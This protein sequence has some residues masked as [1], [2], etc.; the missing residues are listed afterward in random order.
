MNSRRS[1]RRLAALL[2][3]LCAAGPAVVL[4]APAFAADVPAARKAAG[5]LAGQLSEDGTLQNPLGGALPDHGLM[6][7]ALYAMYAAGEGDLARP[8]V[9][10]LDEGKHA[11]D[12]FTWDGLVPGQGYDQVIVGGAAA[13][14]LVAA[15]VARRDP[16][17]FGGYDL[18]TETEGAIMRSGPDKGR[19][20][21]YSKD[22]DLASSVS[23]NANVFGQALG[24]I[25]L[26]GVGRN[27]R[28]AIDKLVTQQCSE[29]YFRIYFGY[30]PT[31]ETGDHVTP[32]GRKVST[33]DEG[34]AHDQSAPDGDAT[35]LALSALVAARRAGAR[36]LDAPIARTVAWLRKRQDAGGGWGGGVS[37]EA[38]NTNS[39]GLIVQA[40]ADAGGAKA[41]VARGQAYL[42]SA[43]ATA[44]DAGNRLAEHVGA[45]AYTP[46][47]YRTARSEGIAGIDTWIRASA[48][49]SL[50]LSQVGFHGLTR[51]EKPGGGTP[52]PGTRPPGGKDPAGPPAKEKPLSPRAGAP[53]P[54]PGSSGGTVVTPPR[55][56]TEPGSPTPAG[57]LGR[58]LA[59]RLVDGDHIEVADG[60]TK[61]VDYDL[62]ADLVL[63][64]RALDEQPR[65]A[66]NASRFLLHP[67]SIKAYA[68]GAPYEKGQA[69]YTEPLAKLRIVGG[70]LQSERRPPKG[71]A[72]TVS[73]LDEDLR[74]LR[75]RD[76]RFGDTGRY[77]DPG[78][79]TRRQAWAALAT[80]A[81]RGDAPLEPLTRARCAD[82]GMP[83]EVDAKGCRT[84]DAAATAT[85]ILALN[86]RPG[87]PPGPALP[88]TVP[89]A[90]T[91]DGWPAGRAAALTRA[92]SA[93]SARSALDGAVR[94]TG[95]RLDVAASAHVAAGRQGA[96]LDATATARTLGGL[97]LRDG[98][99]PGAQTK[100]SDVP[101]SI[102]AA[103]GIAGRAWTSAPGSPVAAAVRLPLSGEAAS[104]VERRAAPASAR[105]S[106]T[107]TVL[108]GLLAACAGFLLRP[109]LARRRAPAPVARQ[110][111]P[112]GPEPP[113]GFGTPSPKD[114]P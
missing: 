21:D 23:N 47:E 24:V 25:G 90:S 107:I 60:R 98:G 43:Q 40:L 95:G 48:Q 94:G 76:G 8:I 55:A 9:R 100:R 4:P 45:I 87:D 81:A 37:T 58:Y 51:G 53:A 78:A 35:G 3:A 68:N 10:Y 88:Q 86:G 7:D 22:P 54:V 49:A 13:K 106:W 65:A 84:G 70:F 56:F 111:V 64:L 101:A 80:V 39:T 12:Y 89:A 82:G 63:A 42:T 26:A 5:W 44:A 52:P 113:P 59:G 105:E 108:V 91:G 61:Y 33:C 72:P 74:G 11:S 114:T 99:L 2:A 71:V 85:A 1:P 77:A 97:L 31:D 29:G 17:S 93:L 103:P 38:P 46:A 62:T 34:K 79:S 36:G 75:G 28:L 41:A 67:A 104:V 83:A 6:I 32:N 73:R 57:R 19:V 14:T 30:V 96:G 16:R 15:L 69:A 102:A 66:R 18:V 20:S 92:A 27:D 112:F 110:N 109:L 50:G